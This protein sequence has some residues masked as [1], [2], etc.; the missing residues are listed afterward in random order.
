MHRGVR[1]DDRLGESV[2]QP[3]SRLLLFPV[4]SP[5]LTEGPAS[6]VDHPH[7]LLWLKSSHSPVIPVTTLAG[8]RR[9]LETWAVGEVCSEVGL[10]SLEPAEREG[11]LLR[12]VGWG[13]LGALK[14]WPA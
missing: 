8:L 14:P 3:R 7:V 9:S 11:D 12:D 4:H 2:W 5:R 1:K 6:S 10:L 13:A